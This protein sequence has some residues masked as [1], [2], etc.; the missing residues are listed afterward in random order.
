[1][2]VVEDQLIDSTIWFHDGLTTGHNMLIDG[3]TSS[4]I[5]LTTCKGMHACSAMYEVN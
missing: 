4:N 3:T 5:D 2:G 1:M